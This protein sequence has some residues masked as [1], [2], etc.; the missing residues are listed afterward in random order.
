MHKKKG[1]AKYPS[2]VQMEGDIQ[3]VT[4]LV[5]RTIAGRE[6]TGRKGKAQLCSWEHGRGKK[7]ILKLLQKP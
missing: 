3:T 2:L 5:K 4:E 6:R 1:Q 7:I